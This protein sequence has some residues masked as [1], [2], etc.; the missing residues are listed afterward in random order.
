MLVLNGY[1]YTN[2]LEKEQKSKT[3]SPFFNPVTPEK[4][5]KPRIIS[6]IYSFIMGR[7][8]DQVQSVPMKKIEQDSK[9][10]HVYFDYG[11]VPNEIENKQPIILK[12][13]D[14]IETE[15]TIPKSLMKRIMNA[16]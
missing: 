16:L 10:K 1:S 11:S 15:H 13:D 12:N 8:I 14:T 5:K 9:P 2:L 3:I 6:N 4:E 7:N